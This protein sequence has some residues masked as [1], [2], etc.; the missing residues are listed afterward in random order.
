MIKWMQK[1]NAFQLA[2]VM[3]AIFSSILAAAWITQPDDSFESTHDLIIYTSKPK[4]EETVTFSQLWQMKE[5]LDTTS[6]EVVNTV[7]GLKM[8]WK[9]DHKLDH[10][11]DKPTTVTTLHRDK[12]RLQIRRYE[13]EWVQ[14][15]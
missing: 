12:Y 13:Y 1:L 7:S 3:I 2:I 5:F 6:Y 11:C 14:I 10:W 8:L 4:I 15:K 9:C